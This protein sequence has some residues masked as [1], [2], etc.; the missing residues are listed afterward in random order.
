[1]VDGCCLSLNWP[2]K[3]KCASHAGALKYQ[4]LD[5]LLIF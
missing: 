5:N 3:A 2:V 1:M 4:L